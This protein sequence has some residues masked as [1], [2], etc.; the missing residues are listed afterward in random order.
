MHTHPNIRAMNEALAID[1]QLDRL[2]SLI[3]A[4]R[5][6]RLKQAQGKGRVHRARLETEYELLGI[7][8]E[9][10]GIDC[11]DAREECA[12]ECLAEYGYDVRDGSFEDDVPVENFGASHPDAGRGFRL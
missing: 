1:A 12:T 2:V 6:A 5:A 4:N 9:V 3:A 10:F 8:E 7:V 11:D